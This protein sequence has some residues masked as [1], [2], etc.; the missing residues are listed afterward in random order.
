MVPLWQAAVLGSVQGLTEFLPISSSAH[1][2]LIPWLFG[3][4]PIS[5]QLTFDVALHLGTLIAVGTYFF[6]DW[7]LIVASYIGDLRQK[8]WLGG[9]KGSLLPKIIVGTIP[10][11]V[12]GKLFED[13]IERRFYEDTGLV[14][15]L[16]LTL[17]VF[18]LF[19]LIAE[20]TGKQKRELQ[21][22]GYRDALIIGVIQCLALIPGVSRSGSTIL[23]G[24]I[25]GLTRPAAAR[26]SFLLATPITAGAVLL[27]LMDLSSSD[28]DASLAVGTVTS[29]VVGL[30]AIWFLL[31]YVQTRRY[32]I[33]VYY[34]WVLAAAV[35]WF[36]L[37]RQQP[38]ESRGSQGAFP[39]GDR[40][41]A[42][43]LTAM[44]GSA[45]AQTGVRNVAD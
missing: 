43:G 45:P 7:L 14:W 5:G 32:D 2:L 18:G 9:A 1:L 36:F 19:L 13:P 37:A 17:A 6:F 40:K 25:L 24:L 28:M 4:K 41:P 21:N 35:L 44:R 10:A 15:V 16:A 23:A 11:A 42:A 34:R 39:P 30:L 31:R 38:G 3:W 33:F 8:R 22:I 27:K 26:F 12:V 20:R 29:A